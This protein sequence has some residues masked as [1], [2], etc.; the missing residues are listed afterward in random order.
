MKV[1]FD[2]KDPAAVLSN[3]KEALGMREL[4]K[5]VEF[6]AGNNSLVVTINKLGT[7]TLIFDETEL[8]DG[9]EYELTKEKIAFTHRAF[10]DDV[11]NKL[12]KVMEK[13]GGKVTH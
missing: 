4:S 10:K 6:N 3:I 8:E 7:S 12:V 1:K 5:M 9:L 13:A 11:T 2:I